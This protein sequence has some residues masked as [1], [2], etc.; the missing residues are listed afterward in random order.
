MSKERNVTART[1]YEYLDEVK[2][3]D[4]RVNIEI[5]QKDIDKNHRVL[6]EIKTNGGSISQLN[7][8]DLYHI[9]EGLQLGIYT[10]Q[11]INK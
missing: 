4:K 11:E 3:D 8:R 7:T 1:I 2:Q 9:L 10:Y 6:W 5:S